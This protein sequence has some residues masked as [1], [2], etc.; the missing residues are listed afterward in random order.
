MSAQNEPID[1]NIQGFTFNAMGWTPETQRKFIVENLGPLLEEKGYGDLKLML[2]D[3]QRV[4]LPFW[5]ENVSAFN[6]NFLLDVLTQ[7]CF[8]LIVVHVI[9]KYGYYRYKYAA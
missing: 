1:G 7:E 4:E 5:A 9:Y 3:D 6:P 8:C 2:L